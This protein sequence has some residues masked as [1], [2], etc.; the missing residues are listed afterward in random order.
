[1]PFWNEQEF[2][3]AVIQAWT[4]IIASN[5]ASDPIRTAQRA[6]TLASELENALEVEHARRDAQEVATTNA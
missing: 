4:G 5:S 6:I 1:M 3:Q 2:E